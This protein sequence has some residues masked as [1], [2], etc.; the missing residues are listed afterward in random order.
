MR[1]TTL[2]LSFVLL[3][4]AIPA[5]AQQETRRDPF[6]GYF[7]GELEGQYRVG[8]TTTYVCE[9]AGEWILMDA[10]MHLAFKLYEPGEQKILK[11]AKAIVMRK[12]NNGMYA[13]NSFDS[14]G[15]STWGTLADEGGKRTM[16]LTYSN[17]YYE[18]GTMV[19]NDQGLVEY[20][21]MIDIGNPCPR[22]CRT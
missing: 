22:L 13:V 3:V 20:T 14:Q 11:E 4:L 1:N 5:F 18:D 16:S 15:I 17:G 19:I 8:K 12:L 7:E 6:L 21:G 10:Y 9:V 2:I